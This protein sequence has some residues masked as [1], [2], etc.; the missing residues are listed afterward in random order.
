[1]QDLGYFLA[2]CMLGES[3]N[4]RWGGTD[5]GGPSISKR[6]AAPLVDRLLPIDL[7]ATNLPLIEVVDELKEKRRSTSIER[8]AHAEARAK[9]GWKANKA[10]LSRRWSIIADT[11]SQ[12]PY[13]A[14]SKTQSSPPG[15]RAG[16][17]EQPAQEGAPMLGRAQP[18]L[19]GNQ[20]KVG[21]PQPYLGAS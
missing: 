18:L 19:T 11:V 10:K 20:E 1:M 17:L 8:L 15:S 4:A 16:R 12:V 13:L 9:D 7:I 5:N 14:R 21:E 3:F 2:G 6:A